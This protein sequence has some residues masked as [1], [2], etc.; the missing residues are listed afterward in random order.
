MLFISKKMKLVSTPKTENQM[1]G[2]LL[3]D[4]VVRE[5]TA[6]FQLLSSKDQPL[7]VWWDSFL[8]LDLCL[9]IFNRVRWLNF[10][11][12]GL[13]SKSF[14]K[15]LHSSSEAENQME[16]GLLLN[17]IVR[18]SSTVFQ[19]LSSKNQPLL[20]WWNSFLVLNL[21]LHIFNRVGRLNL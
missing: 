21:C 8:V 16:G 9:N 2:R 4:V 20:V 6:I 12:N 17:I 11:S 10:K 1:E 19:L 14:D 15:D 7:L 3:L 13:S 5:S 18:K